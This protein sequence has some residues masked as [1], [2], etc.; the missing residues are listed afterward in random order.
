MSSSSVLDDHNSLPTYQSQFPPLNVNGFGGGVGIMSSSASNSTSHLSY[1]NALSNGD[2]NNHT[3]SS[4]PFGSSSYL[5]GGGAA[6]GT[7]AD[8]GDAQMPLSLME[9]TQVRISI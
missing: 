2:V 4:S 6:G 3:A 1:G 5:N 8:S 9:T 7:N